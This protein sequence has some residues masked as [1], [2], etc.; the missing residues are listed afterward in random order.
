M[1]S[2]VKRFSG[3]NKVKVIAKRARKIAA[4]ITVEF[5]RKR[6]SGTKVGKSGNERDSAGC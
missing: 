3:L 2:G 5:M 4:V 1:G 6:R